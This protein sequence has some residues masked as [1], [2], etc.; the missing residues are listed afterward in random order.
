M[1]HIADKNCPP[2]DF[3]TYKPSHLFKYLLAL[4][5]SD[6]DRFG[7][8]TYNLQ[9]SVLH[10]LYTQNYGKKQT[11]ELKEDVDLLFK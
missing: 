9:C 5:N 8:S 10:H 7:A 6:G 3:E 1:L 2:I 4:E 11:T